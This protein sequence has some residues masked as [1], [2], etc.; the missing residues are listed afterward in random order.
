MAQDGLIHV[1]H[2]QRV[3]SKTGRVHLY[4]RKGSFREGPL[5]SPWGSEALRDEVA[6]IVERVTKAQLAQGKPRP[7]TVGGLLRAYRKSAEFLELAA[8]T[9]RD[10]EYLIEEMATD[11][12]DVRIED[13]DR[14]FIRGLRDGWAHRGHRAANNRM[15]V[16]KNALAPVI[17]DDE[18]TRITGDPF[19][20]V[21]KV[22]RPHDAGEANPI[23]QDAEVEVAIRD[24]IARGTPGLAR[25]YALGRYAGFRRG[26]ICAL[27]RHARVTA[28]DA[29]G[30]PERRL[31]WLTEKRKV[32]CDKREDPRLTSVLAETPEQALTVAYNADG[33]PWRERQLSQA[34][35]RHLTR[36]AKAGKVRAAVTEDGEVYCPLTIHGLRHSR[37]VELAEA[38]ASDAEIMAQLEHTTDR[39]AKIYR[40]QAERKRLADRAQ[41][42]V[43]NV[44][45]LRKKATT[46]AAAS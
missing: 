38:G 4:F 30:V 42:Q 22:G 8:S 9:Q 33:H 10:Y 39:A 32:L 44:V 12:D 19:H 17:D 29:V 13:V 7:G 21:K 31:Y 24:A 1:P 27:P 3:I 40:R 28:A 18:D 20:R 14:T 37:G 26:T 35:E 25:A 15:Q 6:A 36:L 34:V 43:D 2:V 23:W 5:S 45:K 11:L 41:D 16:L 46:K